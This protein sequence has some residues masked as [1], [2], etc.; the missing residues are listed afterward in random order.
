MD[1][2]KYFFTLLIHFVMSLQHVNKESVNDIEELQ[3]I[4]NKAIK[5]LKSLLTVVRRHLPAPATAEGT[6][7]LGLRV[8]TCTTTILKEVLEKRTCE[9]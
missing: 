5:A 9:K 2:A 3:L 1:V 6:S 7:F 8:S 4:L